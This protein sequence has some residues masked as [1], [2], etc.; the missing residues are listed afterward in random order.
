M[1]AGLSQGRAPLEESVLLADQGS[2]RGREKLEGDGVVLG[3]GGVNLEDQLDSLSGV[4]GS[5]R[6]YAWGKI[7]LPYP[8]QA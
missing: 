1:L 3:V 4:D 8:D 2:L 5:K 6:L 7:S